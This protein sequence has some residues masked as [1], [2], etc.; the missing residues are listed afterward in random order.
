ME[1]LFM[2]AFTSKVTG[3]VSGEARLYGTFKDLDLYGD[4]YAKDLSLKL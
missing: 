1:H 2:A 4:I 3:E